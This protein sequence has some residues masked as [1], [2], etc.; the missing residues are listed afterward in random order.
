MCI[1]S[2]TN[3]NVIMEL[4]VERFVWEDKFFD[5]LALGMCLLVRSTRIHLQMQHPYGSWKY[6]IFEDGQST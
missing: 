2:I 5:H 3:L 1:T 6:T 4:W